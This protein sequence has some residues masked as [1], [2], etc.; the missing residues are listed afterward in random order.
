MNFEL[1]STV[2]HDSRAGTFG[3]KKIPGSKLELPCQENESI[4]EF[5][6]IAS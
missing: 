4:S 5:P 1:P 3:M 6:M 2:R